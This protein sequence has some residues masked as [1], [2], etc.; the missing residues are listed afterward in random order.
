MPVA[1]AEDGVRQ[2]LQLVGGERA[3]VVEGADQPGDGLL[4][5]AVLAVAMILVVEP[6]EGRTDP[7]GDRV[8]VRQGGLRAPGGS[9]HGAPADL[10]SG[11]AR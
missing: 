2:P 6:V 5:L 10:G 3:R 7:I 11:R 9:I 8:V 4:V 1:V